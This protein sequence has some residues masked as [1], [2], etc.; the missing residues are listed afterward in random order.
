LLKKAKEL[1]S[2]VS[3]FE[4]IFDICTNYLV[5]HHIQLHQP[6]GAIFP[7]PIWKKVVK[8][9]FLPYLSIEHYKKATLS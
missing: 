4:K 6:W 5:V 9:I 3:N 2:H 8:G 1:S 7:E